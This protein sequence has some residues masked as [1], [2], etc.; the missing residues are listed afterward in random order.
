LIL[1][2]G[3]TVLP[4]A[5]NKPDSGASRLYRIL[6]SETAYLIWKLR[7]ERRIEHDDQ[8]AFTENELRKRWSSMLQRR[9]DMDCAMTNDRFGR[10]ALDNTAATNTWERIT[11]G[12]ADRADKWLMDSGV[13]VGS[14]PPDCPPPRVGVGSQVGDP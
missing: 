2:C 13:L 11:R 4:S 14:R 3:A 6:L 7:C 1:G 9:H 12:R 8:K 5:N 10:K